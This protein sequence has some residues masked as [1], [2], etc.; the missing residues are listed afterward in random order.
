MVRL[1]TR[2]QGPTEWDPERSCQFH[3]G[4]WMPYIVLNLD[5]LL[6]FLRRQ[7]PD[8]QIHVQ[9]HH[10]VLG[11]LHGRYLPK[12]CYLPETGTAETAIALWRRVPE[13]GRVTVEDRRERPLAY[14]LGFRVRGA[15]RRTIGR[16]AARGGH[17]AAA[18]SG[19]GT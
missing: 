14:T 11:G 19:G 4:G 18:G 16:L 7:A 12:D 13:P 8:A 5:E 9:R 17:P 2:D 6:A 15:W 3:Y 1:R 10:V